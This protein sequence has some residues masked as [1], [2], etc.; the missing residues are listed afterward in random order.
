MVIPSVSRWPSVRLPGQP[1][2]HKPPYDPGRPDFPGPVLTLT[3]FGRLPDG[4]RLKHWPTYT[5]TVISLRPR[6]HGVHRPN[7]VRLLSVPPSAQSP[8][9]RIGCYLLRRGVSRHISEHYPA[10]IAH[11]RSCANPKPSRRL[12]PWPCSAGLCRLLPAPAGSRTFP[13]LSL[14]IFLCVLGPL[15]RLLLWCLCPFLPT[16]Q[17]PSRRYD[18]VGAWRPPYDSNF[19]MVL[20]SRPQLFDNLQARRFA[21]PPCCPYRNASRNQADRAS[22]SPHISVCY[23]AEQ[24]IC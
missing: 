5:P 14:R 3:S 8:F 22:T 11:T 24:G 6:M 19:R 9:A 15:P 12:R 2:F 1:R 16:G 20:F 7:N 23:L 17:R 4:T 21:R 10:F 13:A 18:P